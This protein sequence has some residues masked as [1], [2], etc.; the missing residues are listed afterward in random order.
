VD[1]A[2]LEKMLARVNRR[3]KFVVPVASVERGRALADGRAEPLL[4]SPAKPKPAARRRRTV[5]GNG[6]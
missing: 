2:E 6:R 3:T 4:G 5:A 1:D